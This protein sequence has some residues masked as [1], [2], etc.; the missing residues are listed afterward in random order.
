[1]AIAYIL[2]QNA[3]VRVEGERLLVKKDDTILHT[4]HLFKCSQLVLLG[5]VMLTPAAIRVLLQQ[6][7]DTVFMSLNGRYRGRLQPP[8]SKNITL[9]CEQFRQL[10]DPHFGLKTARALVTGKISNLRTVLLRLNRSREGLGL[11]DH[12]LGLKQ[13]A[14]KAAAASELDGLRGIE[15]RSA[16]LYFQGFAKGFRAAGIEF[17]KRVRRPPTDPVNALLSLGYTLLFNAMLAAVSL[18]GFDPYL[19]CLHT[20]EYGRPSLALDLMEEWRPIIIDTLVLSVFN[21]KTITREDFV[22]AANLDPECDAEDFDSGDPDD[23]DPQSPPE[24][25]APLPVRL[26][27]AGFRKFITQFERKMQQKIKYHLSNQQL[28]HRDCLRE[29]VRHFARYV[30]GEADRYQPLLLR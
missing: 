9:R 25:K 16:A 11:E 2:E 26:T 14:D 17:S 15:G 8:H 10:S 6:G 21:L 29:Q 5:N 20:V 13:L 24:A 12:I 3:T 30:R 22:I 18:V 19:G 27:D 23:I 4:L 1:M 28:T 7:I